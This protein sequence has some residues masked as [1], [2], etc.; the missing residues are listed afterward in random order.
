M[1]LSP[2]ALGKLEQIAKL[3]KGARIGIMVGIVI[4]LG[5]GY[6]FGVYQG[7]RGDLQRLRAKELELQRKLSEV[8]AVASNIGAFED[9]ITELE[10]RLTQVLEQLPNK[11]QLEVLLTDFSNLG[12]TAGVD[13]NSFTRHDEVFLDFYAE[14]PISIEVVGTYHNIARFFD[15]M[16]QLPRIVNMGALNIQVGSE[17]SER[18]VLKVSG[19]AT[20]FRF[21]AQEESA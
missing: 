6:Y 15:L 1:E 14:V 13:I 12:K 2:E 9:E 8:R 10:G 3:P 18:T 17:N 19:T 20:T 16:A 4:A 5:A 7:A 11:K 21:V